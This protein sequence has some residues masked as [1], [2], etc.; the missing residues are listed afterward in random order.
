MMDSSEFSRFTKRGT[1]VCK[2]TDIYS[3][4]MAVVDGG[5]AG[6]I[7]ALSTDHQHQHRH[8]HRVHGW[9]SP[10]CTVITTSHQNPA[11]GV[12]RRIVEVEAGDN[13]RMD[14]PQATH[15]RPIHYHRRTEAREETWVCNNKYPLDEPSSVKG[16]LRATMM[17]SSRP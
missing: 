12:G 14:E 10:S 7:E 3:P 13:L 11:R 9:G 17:L 15:R 6:Q 2:E 1:A 8:H 16:T 4:Y 5:Q